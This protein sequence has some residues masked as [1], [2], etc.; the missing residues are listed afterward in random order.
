MGV[1]KRG[2]ILE[3][4]FDPATVFTEMFLK[5]RFSCKLDNHRVQKTLS[6]EGS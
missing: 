2:D 1:G 3:K 5:D 6:G 4:F